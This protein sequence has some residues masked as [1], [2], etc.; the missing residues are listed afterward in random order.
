MAAL[1]SYRPVIKCDSSS[2]CATPILEVEPM[3]HK[4]TR[5]KGEREE[6]YACMQTALQGPLCTQVS[7]VPD[8]PRAYG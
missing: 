8:A 3:S 5:L 2:F 1:G 4:A 7:V 6:L